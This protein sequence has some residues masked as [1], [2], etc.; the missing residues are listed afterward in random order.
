MSHGVIFDCDGV[1]VNTEALVIEIEIAAM[2][3]LGVSYERE[4]FIARYL[5]ASEPDFEAGLNADH[6]AVHG[7]PLPPGFFEQMK[8]DRY[9]HL[10]RHIQAVPGA[11]AFAEAL[12]VPR[13]V[14]SS[15]ERAA[16]A[17]KLSKTGLADLFKGQVHSAQDVARGKPAP[18]LYHHA[19]RALGVD[20]GASLAIEDSASGVKSAVAA[21]MTCWGLTGGGHCPAGHGAT[22]RA[23]GAQAVFESFEAMKAAYDAAGF[24]SGGRA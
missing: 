8:V 5:G 17:M 11:R 13:A 20:P 16:L 4:A 24:A 6:A 21:G 23:A 10:E 19:S 18:D 7:T 22:L 12:S 9:A 3:Q 15:S 14:A 2:A 1:L